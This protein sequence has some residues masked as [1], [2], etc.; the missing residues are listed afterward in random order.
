MLIE[1]KYNFFDEVYLKTDR[2][3][4]KRIITRLNVTPN[5]VTYELTCGTQASWHYDQEISI[6]K[7]V[8]TSTE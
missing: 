5:G 7:N 1:A 2:D 4:F 3:Q 8:L 6:E